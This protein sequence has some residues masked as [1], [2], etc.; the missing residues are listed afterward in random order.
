MGLEGHKKEEEKG[1]F[2]IWIFS[3][4]GVIYGGIFGSH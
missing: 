2:W 3:L 1:L 4:F